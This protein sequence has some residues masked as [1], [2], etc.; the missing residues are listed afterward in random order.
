MEHGPRLLDD[1]FAPITFSI[2]FLEAPFTSVIDA[3]SAWRSAIGNYPTRPLAGD[4]PELLSALLPLTGPLARHLWVEASDGWTAYF[5][6]FINGGDP[7]GTIVQLSTSLGCRGVM[8]TCVPATPT[9]YGG[10]RFDLYGQA[11]TMSFNC[12]RTVAAID[13]DGWVWSAEGAVQ[14][15]EETDAYRARRIRDRLTPAM[16]DRYCRALGIRA[17][18]ADFYRRSGL[19]VTNGNLRSEPRAETLAEAQARLRNAP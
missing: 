3:D 2:G 9:T 7:W 11:P 14:P 1:R 12:T 15:F 17:F 8:C 5:D 6:N 18:D 10:T 19:L 16:I 13:D 4:L